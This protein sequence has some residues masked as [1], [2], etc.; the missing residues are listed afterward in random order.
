MPVPR[1]KV[2]GGSSSINGMVYVRGNRANFDSWAAE[3]NTGWDADSRQRGV[4][5]DGGLRGRRQRLPRRRRA[6][7]D[8]PQ[9]DP[10]GGHPAVH[11]GHLRRAGREDPR[12]LQRASRRRASA[13]CSRT[14]PT[15]CAT[16]PHAATC[17]TS[18]L[19]DAAAA[20]AGA[21]HQG[22]HRERPGDRASRSPTRTAPG[23]RSAPARRS[24]SPPASSARAQLLMLSGIGHAEHL[25]RP[26]H[27]RRRRP[28][29]RRQPA[30]PHVPRADLPRDARRR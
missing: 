23:A 8:H 30:R 13:G 17:T 16:A 24:S 18:R 4:Q 9:H 10:A 19:P 3:G 28:A 2:V 12:R 15:A 1:G 5:A 22:G 6:D 11:P 29:G 7:P 26:R 25:Q 27:H 21:G 14:P 20:V